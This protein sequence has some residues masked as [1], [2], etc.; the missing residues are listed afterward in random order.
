MRPALHRPSDLNKDKDKDSDEVISMATRKRRLFNLLI[1]PTTDRRLVARA[2]AAGITKSELVRRLIADEAQSAESPFQR[3]MA[4][5]GE[6]FARKGHL[7]ALLSQLAPHE[8]GIL[9]SVAAADQ[10]T[11]WEWSPR[12]SSPAMK[13]AADVLLGRIPSRLSIDVSFP[14]APPAATPAVD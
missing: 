2:K 12:K 14:A 3:A 7:V 4:L 10:D 6:I 9:T 1:D 13:Q 8:L 5:W 11:L